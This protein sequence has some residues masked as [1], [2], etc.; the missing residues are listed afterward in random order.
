MNSMFKDGYQEGEIKLEPSPPAAENLTTGFVFVLIPPI[1]PFP[2][3][4]S[5]EHFKEKPNW[6]FV[7]P[8]PNTVSR[9]RICAP[10]FD[11][12]INKL[13]RITKP[14][15][16]KLLIEIIP[17]LRIEIHCWRRNFFSR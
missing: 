3:P 6:A 13:I 7:D 1:S 16:F 9:L 17:Q 4:N 11:S 5:I 15:K 8:E 14:M 12:A 10:T 2:Q